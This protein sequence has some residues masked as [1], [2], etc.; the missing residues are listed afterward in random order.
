MKT[1]PRCLAPLCFLLAALLST[2]ATLSAINT[3]GT[4]TVTSN[5]TVMAISA[6][7]I[8]IAG[9]GFDSVAANDTVLFN[10]GA[11]GAVTSATSTLL[12]VTFSTRP[13]ATGALTA[14]VTTN[15]KSSGA[16]VQVAL[17]ASSVIQ[18]AAASESVAATTGSFSIPVTIAGNPN[19]S[20]GVSPYVSSLG[21]FDFAS[22]LTLDAAHNLYVVTTNGVVFKQPPGGVATAFASGF[23]YNN[24]Q[25]LTCDAAGNLY[26]ADRSANT[27]SKVTPDGTVSVFASGFSSPTKMT[28]DTAGNLYVAN[29]GNGSVS[30][31]TAAG[32]VSTFAS[33]FSGPF[34]LAF[35]KAGNLYVAN[36]SNG[37]VSLVTPS[38]VTSTF[39]SGLNQPVGLAFDTQGNLFV[40]STTSSGTV[41][42]ANNAL[43]TGLSAIPGSI[44]I[45][46]PP[47]PANGSISE[48]SP[49]G[50]VSSF[51][52]G[53]YSPSD[54]L[55][56]AAGNLYV[57][58]SDD[59]N[60]EYDYRDQ[61]VEEYSPSASVNFTI[62]G[63]A[64]SG[65][66]YSGAYGNTGYNSTT[67][68]FIAGQPTLSITGTLSPN[69]GAT[70]TLTFTLNTPNGAVIGSP[71]TNTLTIVEPPP[72]VTSNTASVP[73]NTS[74][75]TLNGYF[76]PIAANNTVTFN[77]GA[78]GTV[79]TAS[80]TSLTVTFSTQ[81][82]ALGAL[83]ASVTSNGVSSGTPVT[84]A[85][86]VP[87]VTASNAGLSLN[88]TVLTINGVGFDP[89][90]AHNTVVLSNGLVGTVTSATATQLTVSLTHAPANTGNIY[91]IVTT[92]GLSSVAPVAIGTVEPTVQFNVS[93][94]TLNA[95]AG[96]FSIPITITGDPT[97]DSGAPP[98]MGT[99][100][101][102]YTL[103]Y[104][105]PSAIAFD[106]AGNLYLANSHDGIVTKFAP[107][108]SNSVFASGF[109]WP[110]GVAFDAAGNL[111]LADIAT[112]NIS[113]ISPDGNVSPY[114]T[115]YAH[116]YSLTFD[117]AGNLYVAYADSNNNGFVDKVTPA[118]VVTTFASG[119]YAPTGL[120]FDAAGNLYVTESYSG[121]IYR[122][123][124]AG[125]VSTFVPYINEPGGVTIDASGNLY[126]SDYYEGGIY[127]IT[128]G[129]VVSTLI[130]GVSEPEGLAF[131]A[132]G[133]LFVVN[134]LGGSG[135]ISELFPTVFVPFAIGGTGVTGTDYNSLTPS[136]MLF[137]KG[138]PPLSISGSLTADPGVTPTLIF[139]LGTPQGAILGSRATNTL[140]V[141][142]PPPSVASSTAN[143]PINAPFLT[144]QGLFNPVAANNTV[145]FNNGAAGTVT[146]ATASSL[147]VT[148]TTPP[149]SLGALT[150]TVVSMGLSTGVPVQ[151]A[152]IIP[153]VTVT[154]SAVSLTGNTLTIT[155]LGF[156]PTASHNIVTLSNGAVGTVTAATAKQLTVT[157][158]TLPTS[159]GGLTATVTTDGFT[160]GEAVPIA[161]V[162]P[163][164]QF[165]VASE[166]VNAANGAFSI[167]VTLTGNP[168]YGAGVTPANQTLAYGVS[169]L[170]LAADASG[171]IYA[172]DSSAGTVL[173]IAP[174][175]STS[176]F[177][178]GLTSPTSLAVDGTGNVYVGCNTYSY[179]G[180]AVGT[181]YRVTPGGVVSLFVAAFADPVGLAFD[182]AGNLYVAS[183]PQ[184][185]NASVG[186]VTPNG[187][188]ST[189]ATGF[190]FVAGLAF[191]PAGNLYVSG[192]DSSAQGVISKVTPYGNVST[193]ATG[194]SNPSGLAF[195]SVGNLY[196]SDGS[197][198]IVTAAGVISTFTTGINNPN[199]LTFDPA[200]NLYVDCLDQNSSGV[201]AK[202]P[203]TTTVPYTVSGTAVAGL[204]YSGLSSSPVTFVN[205][206]PTVYIT[207][208]LIPN[209]N[210]TPF[211]TFTLGTPGGAYLGSSVSNTL[212]ILEPPA[213]VTPSAAALPINATGIVLYGA[214]D[215]VVANNTV[216]FNDGAIGA[217]TSASATALT[218]TFSTPPTSLGNLTAT[219]ITAGMSTGAPVPVATVV[220]IA[221]STTSVVPIN[222]TTI[223]INGFGF[224]PIVAN[225]TVTFSNGTVGTV[226]AASS[227]QLTVT[228]TAPLTIA[229]PLTAIV[230]TDGFTGGVPVQIASVDPTVH[231]SVSA[232]TVNDTDGAFSVAVTLTGT[233]TFLTSGQAT[234]QTV[235]PGLQAT[236]MRCDA[237][238]NLYMVDYSDTAI[239]KVTPDRNISTFGTGSSGNRGLAIDAAGNLYVSNYIY[240]TITKITPDGVSSLFVSGINEPEAM[241][242]D[243]A[244]NLYV[245]TYVGNLGAVISKVSPTGAISSF[246]PG[247][248]SNY[249]L[250]GLTFDKSGNLYCVSA[251]D[252]ITKIT[253]AGVAS[254]F[255]KGFGWAYLND[256]AFDSAGNLFANGSYGNIGFVTPDG[257]THTVTS[258]YYS[259]AAI[260]FD[261]AGHLYVSSN[262]DVDELLPAVT[263]YYTV[264]G[265]ATSYSD[266]TLTSSSPLTL[267][268]AQPTANVTGTL[269]Y[270]AGSPKTVTLTLGTPSGAVVGTP[271]VNTMTINFPS[272]V[273]TSA[274]TSVANDSTFITILGNG[275]DSN[276]G[277]NS[278]VFSSGAVGTIWSATSTQL[279]VLL[280]H[281]PTGLG[282]LTAVVT[283][284]GQS[285]GA[286]IQ[287]GNVVPFGYPTGITM[288]GGTVTVH[289]HATPYT[290]YTL[291]YSPSLS[292]A[293]WTNV[294]SVSTDSSG[295]TQYSGA[296]PSGGA[297]YYR[298]TH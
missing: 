115:G 221:T 10:D 184:F 207:G 165:G 110:I 104:S 71:A 67:L 240:N 244:G 284:D 133:H 297:G 15:G 252:T 40:A 124:P 17:V 95:T 92:N 126:V 154:A 185:G 33:G 78:V 231:F 11:V 233:P 93:S 75:I 148:F 210:A 46:G 49:S 213:T 269:R 60:Y 261:P 167:P 174:D 260:A 44:I 158:T 237:A 116:L 266:Y 211:L 268:T 63:T 277:N 121:S 39:A 287:I 183:A 250:E 197:L 265:T 109:S 18:F 283:T 291:Q 123:T 94:E 34:G 22:A 139:T 153:V 3:G 137:V 255:T 281:R 127:K 236:A 134:H 77:D 156:D 295:N 161:L 138:M 222:A 43:T 262:S 227:T 242:F 114:L 51:A 81:P 278:V 69:A 48:V 72:T 253:P 188:T 36:S 30:K 28:F 292:P 194:L 258:S 225:N 5:S 35:D 151:V 91:A 7:T 199:G 290:G 64:M 176:T 274:T 247:F 203:A 205:G 187:T 152:T 264:G 195:D 257:T 155:G 166:S 66:D 20:N 235:A 201:V 289:F 298:L 177:A 12:T 62:G 228:L 288:T 208:I 132:A 112:G 186:K 54:M 263:V 170:G 27:V 249:G 279:T 31:V 19:F 160:S 272:P 204:D 273:V 198:K 147:T 83:K 251:P 267:T 87:G 173:K 98:V 88:G 142:E 178:S 163:I 38:G 61:I 220:P 270:H 150:A 79:T 108:G 182:A 215:P 131:D 111:F 157:L 164:A 212:T 45:V 82:Q 234:V 224:D 143:L 122:V 140:T 4:P 190:R 172:V 149:A 189:F 57:T 259:G 168:T 130:S 106:S 47:P 125:V 25:G 246:A 118:K 206:Q 202:L 146:S 100:A 65:T 1:S 73:I 226:T 248:S 275:F 239:T 96:T 180:G 159:T 119:F 191:D 41:V 230:T 50:V 217:V 144:I 68:T 59:M 229:G 37:T 276:S 85:T 24:A 196:V 53:L 102:G 103:G 280:S 86:L 129:G 70:R 128:P 117:A 181:I 42:L 171:N 285:S 90:A 52:T 141:T 55:S 32:V 2:T 8:T 296:L 238:G 120:V 101:S 223:T 162:E 218:V 80:S 169:N 29:T 294:T 135:T 14:V 293:A 105:Y 219:V 23:T 136:P 286:P 13:N 89:I 243:G 107:D 256:L 21:V 179:Y 84:V 245:V 6:T 216:T 99:I 271:G 26:V 58:D 16:A 97:F 241:A 192:R 56:D 214:F 9:T 76:S 200:G 175:G 74:T 193:F 113:K 232:E 282:A 254:T 145:T 209:L